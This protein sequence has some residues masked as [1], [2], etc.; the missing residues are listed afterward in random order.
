[1]NEEINTNEHCLRCFS[2]I[3][4]NNIDNCWLIRCIQCW[5]IH[6]RINL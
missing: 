5:N 1:M 3:D 4:L 2:E 6:E